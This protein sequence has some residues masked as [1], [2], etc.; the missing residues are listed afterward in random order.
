MIDS[1]RKGRRTYEPSSIVVGS[2]R[3]G[4][5]EANET[6]GRVVLESNTKA[7]VVAIV[8]VVDDND[9]RNHHQESSSGIII[10]DDD[11]D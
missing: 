6:F 11:A 9:I 4:V 5:D 3:S 1:S 10:D 8:V 2:R 7:V